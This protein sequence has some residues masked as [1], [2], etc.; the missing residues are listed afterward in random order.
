MRGL[1]Q[2]LCDRSVDV[3]HSHN[4]G[5]L[6][7]TVVARRWCPRVRHVHAVHGQEL[8]PFRVT[9]WKRH[10]RRLLMRW[11]MRQ[12]HAVVAIANSVQEW[13]ARDCGLQPPRLQYIPN[14]VADPQVRS[15]DAS[16]AELRRSLV[17]DSE[18]L[19]I[20]SVSRLIP[21]KDFA[22]AIEA[23]REVVR[24]GRDAHLV[25]VGEGAER[26]NLESKAVAR[27]L[28]DRVHFVGRQTNV[29]DWLSCFDV[30]IN[31]S[32]TEAMSMALLEAMAAE[33]PI[34]ATEVGDA[35]AL[36]GGPEPA[37]LLVPPADSAALAAAIER[38]LGDGA[39]R[40]T[41]AGA[42]RRRYEAHYA[43]GRMVERYAELYTNLM[44]APACAGV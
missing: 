16:A 11:G 39:E 40:R 23:V 17:I 41:L 25:L 33:L 8:D 5:T 7:E 10:V 4:W 13:L 24:G 1:G 34:V 6:L 44:P 22:S 27:G 19:V 37:G 26:G 35:A 30:Y 18:A 28:H 3:I 42:G 21:L 43:I 9:G 14:G 38:L 2:V 20:G 15:A 12:T 36:V 32:R 31:S 29:G